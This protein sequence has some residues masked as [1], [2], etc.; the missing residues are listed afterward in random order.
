MTRVLTAVLVGELP[1]RVRASLRFGRP[2]KVVRQ[3]P[4]MRCVYFAPE[5][6][7]CRLT[8]STAGRGD[9]RCL[10][11]LRVIHPGERCSEL[12]GVA[13]GAEILLRT[14]TTPDVDRVLVLLSDI[15]SRG[16]RLEMVAPSYWRVVHNR[17]RA[18]VPPIP[19]SLASHLASLR[20]RGAT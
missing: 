19:F 6:V 16:I 10:E 5:T 11:V 9:R 20:R 12:V 17:L 18:G 13:P 14:S 4:H 3:G 8:E 7:L 15:S 2:W 1:G